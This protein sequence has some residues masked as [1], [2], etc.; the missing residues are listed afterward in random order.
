M[1]LVLVI[2][3]LL[4]FWI[5]ILLSQLLNPPFDEFMMSTQISSGVLFTSIRLQDDLNLQES[6][7]SDYL[8]LPLDPNDFLEGIELK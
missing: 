5:P 3:I 1:S 4:V 2:Y 8:V 6:I 7:L